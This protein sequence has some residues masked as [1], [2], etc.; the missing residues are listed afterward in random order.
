MGAER[1]S[2]FTQYAG[3]DSYCTVTL[4]WAELEIV[5]KEVSL[6]ITVSV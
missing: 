4:V 5:D 2:L 6:P 3:L 1:A